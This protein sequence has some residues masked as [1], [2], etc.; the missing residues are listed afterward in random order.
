MS[1]STNSLQMKPLPHEWKREV[2]KHSWYQASCFTYCVAGGLALLFPESLEHHLPL[3]PWRFTGVAVL[4][5]GI[6]SYMADVVTWGHDSAWK[7]V[8]VFIASLNMCLQALL[9]LLCLAGFSTFPRLP[10]L[11]LG[12][13]FA[14]SAYARVKAMHAAEEYKCS[15]FLYWHSLW[16]WFLPAGAITGQCILLCSQRHAQVLYDGTTHAETRAFAKL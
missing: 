13:G 2:E 8:D 11:A 14:G 4:M 6:T 16:H 3:F 15:D 9:L 5:N 10:V 7:R 12:A 1:F